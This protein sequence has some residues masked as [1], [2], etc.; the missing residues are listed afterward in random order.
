MIGTPPIVLIVELTN[1]TIEAAVDR[2]GV[3]FNDLS[4]RAKDLGS[5]AVF[6]ALIPVV[7]VW[8]LML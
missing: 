1:S 8:G 7:V 2:I 6:A 3:E 5:S 4:R